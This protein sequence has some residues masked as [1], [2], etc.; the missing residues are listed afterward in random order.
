MPLGGPWDTGTD[1]TGIEII[2]DRVV[3]KLQEGYHESGHH[4]RCATGQD[5]GCDCYARSTIGAR[6]DVAGLAA[7]AEAAAARAERAEQT[8]R[9]LRLEIDCRIE[10]GADSGGHLEY[11]R[12]F[13]DRGRP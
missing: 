6:L 9:E 5:I 11:V 1:R 8:L 13:I 4:P 3:A 2:R 12:S 7:C 10:H